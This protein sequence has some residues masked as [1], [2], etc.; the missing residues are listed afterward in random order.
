[1]MLKNNPSRK[2]ITTCLNLEY[3]GGDMILVEKKYM[4]KGPNVELAMEVM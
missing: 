1:M 2:S 3:I 4:T